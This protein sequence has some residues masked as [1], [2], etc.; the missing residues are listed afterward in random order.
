MRGLCPIGGSTCCLR[1]SFSAGATLFIGS[2][3][4]SAAAPGSHEVSDLTT[5][6]VSGLTLLLPIVLAAL[7]ALSDSDLGS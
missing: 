7:A 6:S 5:A 3:D 2:G 4:R 1:R